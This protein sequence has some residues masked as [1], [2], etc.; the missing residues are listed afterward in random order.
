MRRGRHAELHAV[1]WLDAEHGAQMLR[2]LAPDSGSLRNAMVLSERLGGLPLALHNA[3]SQLASESVA[4][5]TLRTMR[6]R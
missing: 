4:E 1:G 2:D 3:G 6:A 5:Q